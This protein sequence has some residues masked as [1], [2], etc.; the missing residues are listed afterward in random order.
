MKENKKNQRPVILP[1]S[2]GEILG[3][4]C[5]DSYEICENTMQLSRTSESERAEYGISSAQCDDGTPFDCGPSGGAISPYTEVNAE[6]Q[7]VISEVPREQTFRPND[8]VGD[9]K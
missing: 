2:N 5:E 7:G 9:I 4:V 6:N 8:E 3:L 1:D